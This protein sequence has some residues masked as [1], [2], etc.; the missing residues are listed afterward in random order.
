MKPNLLTLA[1]ILICAAPLK[2]ED[3]STIEDPDLPILV[4]RADKPVAFIGLE[5][6]RQPGSGCAN[7]LGTFIVDEIAYS[8][9]SE[10]IDGIR[11]REVLDSSTGEVIEEAASLIRFDGAVSALSNAEARWISHLVPRGARLLIAYSI[12]GSGNFQYA[13]DIYRINSGVLRFN[14]VGDDPSLFGSSP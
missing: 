6:V 1:L 11:V 4:F 9:F 3:V 2:A 14:D 13:R 10:I 7:N 5:N 8:G 12:C